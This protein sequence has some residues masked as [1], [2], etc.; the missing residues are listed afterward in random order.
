MKIGTALLVLAVTGGVGFVAV[1]VAE[2]PRA[3]EQSKS[4]DCDLLAAQAI[5]IAAG[6]ARSVCKCEEAFRARFSAAD[7]AACVQR[8]IDAT[9]GAT[10][11]VMQQRAALG[12]CPDGLAPHQRAAMDEHLARGQECARQWGARMTTSR[13]AKAAKRDAS[14]RPK[15]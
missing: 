4:D 7:G 11:A 3:N 12:T 9:K 1:I 5:E 14:E 8:A 15:R 10:A 13:S 2:M 6:A